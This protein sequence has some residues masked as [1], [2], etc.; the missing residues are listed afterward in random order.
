MTTT[1]TQESAATL[2]IDWGKCAG[3]GLC[4]ELLE[5][6]LSADDWGYP[7]SPEG[8]NVSIP[9]ELLDAAQTAA[10]ACPVRALMLLK[11]G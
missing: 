5:E 7:Y 4:I 8:S 6:K 1:V 11:K 10:D 3:H 9:A 2:N